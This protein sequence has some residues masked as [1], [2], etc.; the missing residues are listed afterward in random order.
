MKKL[1]IIISMVLLLSCCGVDFH[2]GKRPYDYPSTK[3]V[4]EDPEI[5]FGG[6]YDHNHGF[7]GLLLVDGQSIEINVFFNK[8]SGV[9]FTKRY[10]DE[11]GTRGLCKFSPDKLIVKIDKERDTYFNGRYKTITFFRIFEY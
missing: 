1:L 6:R 7:D 4:S 2:S 11:L 9:S 8:G 3:W 5:W 10:E